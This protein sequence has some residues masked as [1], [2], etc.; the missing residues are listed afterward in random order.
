MCLWQHGAPAARPAG[1]AN[2]YCE[3]RGAERQGCQEI[4][5]ERPVPR[6]IAIRQ[7]E[8][9]LR[10]SPAQLRDGAV[11]RATPT[12][13]WERNKQTEKTAA[14]QRASAHQIEA[15][16]CFAF[17]ICRSAQRSIQRVRVSVAL[18]GVA[19]LAVN[20]FVWTAAVSVCTR[21]TALAPTECSECPRPRRTFCGQNWP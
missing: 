15:A 16:A 7:Q 20:Q 4:R 14:R 10:H 9:D 18:V 12:P 5:T 3:L 11:Y 2:A 17:R 13:T 1:R 8:A 19:L 21:P 6:I